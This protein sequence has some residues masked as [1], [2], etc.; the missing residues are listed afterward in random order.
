MR[1]AAALAL[2]LVLGACG[3][4][5]V[6]GGGRGE[7][8]VQQT[9]RPDCPETITIRDFADLRRYRAP[10]SHDLTDLVV[11]ARI[12]GVAGRCEFRDRRRNVEVTLALTMQATRGPASEDRRVVLPYFVAVMDREDRILNKE[13]FEVVGE[14]PANRSRVRMTGEEVALTLPI[15]ADRPPASYTVV[16]GFQLTETELALNRR[17]GVR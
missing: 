17:L 14:F 15:T 12:S 10:G 7:A 3:E 4:G 6:R 2:V 13:I 11:E 1:V 8:P 16:V 9:L 5:G